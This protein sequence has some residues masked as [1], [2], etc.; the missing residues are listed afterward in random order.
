[1]E[2]AV[3]P[4]KLNS[5]RWSELRREYTTG[6]TSITPS[7]KLLEKKRIGNHKNSKEIRRKLRKLRKELQLLMS[8]VGFKF[9]EVFTCFFPTFTKFYE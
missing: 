8:G 7:P 6:T 9:R 1:M 5:H 3:E 4:Q 2:E